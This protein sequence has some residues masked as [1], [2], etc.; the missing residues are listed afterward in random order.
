MPALGP[1][2]RH[3]APGSCPALGP[4][5]VIVEFCKYGNLSNFLRAKREAF[6]PYAVSGSPASGPSSAGSPQDAKVGWGEGE[7]GVECLCCGWPSP[8]QTHSVPSQEKSPEQRRRFR[9][10]VEGA[11]ADR[12]RPGGSERV[13]LSRLLMGK[14]GAGRAPPV[15]EG[16]SLA[17]PCRKRSGWQE[18][19]S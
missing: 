2:L 5:M 14:G 15:Q 8:P 19:A 7:G 17:S 9:A 13:L 10:M 4:L 12:R 18:D 11:K 1:A 16:K 3:Q 6:S